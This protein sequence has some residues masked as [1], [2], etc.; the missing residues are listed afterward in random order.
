MT[1]GPLENKRGEPK[2]VEKKNM[3]RVKT[4]ARTFAGKPDAVRPPSAN[5]F[6]IAFDSNADN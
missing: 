5:K 1:A 6:T 4:T 3:R 2:L